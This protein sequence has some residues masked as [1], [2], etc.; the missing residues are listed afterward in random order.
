MNITFCDLCKNEQQRIA[1]GTA[2]WRANSGS[3]YHICEECH[4]KIDGFIDTLVI[5]VAEFTAPFELP[6]EE[7]NAEEETH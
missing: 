7:P 3:L 2:L 4:G 6:K 5:P 1:T